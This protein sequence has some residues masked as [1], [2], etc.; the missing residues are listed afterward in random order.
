M[1]TTMMMGVGGA[2]IGPGL[3]KAPTG[4]PGLDQVTGGGL[5]RG[6][7]SL[8]AGSAGAGKTLLDHGVELVEVYVGPAGVLAGSARL[9]QE[10]V[11]R[12]AE[13]HKADELERHLRELRNNITEREAHL[14]AVRDQLAAEHTE[15]DRIDRRERRHVA[16]TEADRVTMAS[17][18]WA[19]AAPD[20]DVTPGRRWAEKAPDNGGK[21]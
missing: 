2:T 1:N 5:P 11:E 17:Q 10:A 16:D 12:D 3:D 19:D 7:V 4:I 9:A 14:V 18:R 13:V 8:V 21:Q 15:I 6:R 20:P